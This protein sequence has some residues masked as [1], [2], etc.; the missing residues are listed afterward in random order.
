[1]FPP[2]L[3][4]TLPSSYLS[5]SQTRTISSSSLCKLTAIHGEDFPCVIL[6]LFKVFSSPFP[7]PYSHLSAQ[8]LPWKQQKLV[9]ASSAASIQWG[10]PSCSPAAMH[11]AQWP[12]LLPHNRLPLLKHDTLTTKWLAQTYNSNR[13]LNS[14]NLNS[15]WKIQ[16]EVALPDVSFAPLDCPK[17]SLTK[18]LWKELKIIYVHYATMSIN[19]TSD[20]IRIEISAVDNVQCP[21]Q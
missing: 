17:T 18:P 11:L 1:M 8:G 21:F 19:F 6:S 9:H 10:W 15:E 16:K 4:L 5:P 2:F 13:V 14:T 12:N 20:L 3:H 7:G